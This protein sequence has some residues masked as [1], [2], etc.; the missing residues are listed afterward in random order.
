MNRKTRSL[1]LPSELPIKKIAHGALCF[2]VGWLFSAGE[3]FIGARPF[4]FSLLC[5][6]TGRRASMFSYLGSLAGSISTGNVIYAAAY[7]AVFLIRLIFSLSV[8]TSQAVKPTVSKRTATWQ[9]IARY[10]MYKLMG[11][12]FSESVYVRM[13]LASASSMVAGAV[14]CAASGYDMMTLAGAA[15]SGIISP[16][17]VYLYYVVSDDT[18]IEAPEFM[19]EA[20]RCAVSASFVMCLSSLS[21]SF[22]LAA[23]AAFTLTLLATRNRGVLI[24]CAYG[25][26]LG[27]V[28]APETALMYA[29][30]A[31]ASGALWKFSPATATASACTAGTLWAL[32]VNGPT[33]LGTVAPELIITSAV[34][35]PLCAANVLPSPK[36]RFKRDTYKTSEKIA[37]ITQGHDAKNRMRSLSEGMADLSGVLYRLS[38][39]LTA[40]STEELCELCETS[41]DEYCKNCGM[42]SACFGREARQTADMQARMTLSMKREG[43]VS[44]SVVPTNIA[45]R[46]YNMGQIIDTMNAGCSRLVSE[47]K[48]YDRT[49]V[50]ASDYEVMADMLRESSEYDCNEYECD[51]A[52]TEKLRRR[53]SQTSFKAERTAVFGKRIKRVVARS[54]NVNSA[55]VGADEIRRL[56]SNVCGTEM[57]TPEFSIDGNSVT[58]KLSALPRLSVKCGRSS[59][60]MSAIDT[61]S[62]KDDKADTATRVFLTG[63]E[64]MG[65]GKTSSEDCGDVISAF[66][67]DDGRFFMLISD[68]MGSGHEAAVTSGICAIFIEKLLRAG[69]SMDTAL[70]MLNSMMR[71]RNGECSATV[72]LMELDLMNGCVRFVKSGAAPSFVLR[73]GRLFRLQSKTVPIGIMRA[74]DA[75]MIKF[76][77]EPGDI[78]VMLSDGVA[79]SFED[80]PW[81]YDLLC[82]ENEWTGDMEQMAKKIVKRAIEN[83][84]DDD[85]T[86]G[87]VLVSEAMHK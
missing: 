54:V 4:A 74:L 9:R 38:D 18:V 43:R 39:K 66:L 48:L 83:G 34:L 69:A 56:V 21:L 33:S 51:E 5:A 46:C 73:G 85:I 13:M 22:D 11:A 12:S 1:A 6:A 57:S 40:P 27:A 78:I 67:T 28:H 64:R 60:A 8:I 50:V 62:K 70:K 53:L 87:V 37:L 36:S 81:L 25:V 17:L 14:S 58:M 31:I 65:I 15:V 80:C 68:G 84:A 10:L 3:F 30:S 75:E 59:V 71:V 20:G 45:K 7:T 44:A 41:F 52:M 26:V 63:N 42:K 23:S 86:A 2:G 29:I 16:V 49:A 47:A 24:G 61:N 35:A 72:D 76:E 55:T 82:D 77:T 19:K 79:K 32:Y